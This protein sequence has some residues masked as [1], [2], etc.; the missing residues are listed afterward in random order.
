MQVGYVEWPH[1]REQLERK[2]R[3]GRS[4]SRL[5]TVPLTECWQEEEGREIRVLHAL[6]NVYFAAG[7]QEGGTV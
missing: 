3:K 4:L 7:S 2:L 5:A 6:E 1:W